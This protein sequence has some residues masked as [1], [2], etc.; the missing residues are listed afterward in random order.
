MTA[1]VAV[2]DGITDAQYGHFHRKIDDLTRRVRNGHPRGIGWVNHEIQRIAEGR[3]A[4]IAHT[5]LVTSNGF[6][7][8]DWVRFLAESAAL[9]ITSD[10][11]ETS[12]LLRR[13]QL[14]ISRHV[15]HRLV[16]LPSRTVARE[17]GV[18][19]AGLTYTAVQES[20]LRRSYIK[21]TLEDVLLVRLTISDED[22]KWMGL[23]HLVGM[24]D[25]IMDASNRPRVLVHLHDLTTRHRC[26]Y[27]HDGSSDVNWATSAVG[28]VFRMT[29]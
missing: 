21:P 26:A 4:E 24:H 3:D 5:F 23:S 22:I 1:T 12:V 8:E 13:A 14:R 29:G 25:P 27:F 18:R 7:A 16:I 10:T 2:A 9:D 6:S 28:F 11:H 20:A 15:T 17:C 19:I